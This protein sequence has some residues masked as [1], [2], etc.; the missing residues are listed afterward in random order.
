[1]GYCDGGVT[2]EAFGMPRGA[3]LELG[4]LTQPQPFAVDLDAAHRLAFDVERPFRGGSWLAHGGQYSVPESRRML[5]T[6]LTCGARSSDFRAPTNSQ[7]P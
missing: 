5:R 1:L 4:T 6:C 7:F 3:L 2:A